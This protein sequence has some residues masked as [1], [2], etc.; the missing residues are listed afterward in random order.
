MKFLKNAAIIIMVAIMAL[1][2]TACHPK[3]EVAVTVGEYEFTSGYYLCAL[4]FADMEAR[5]KVDEKLAE[6]EDYDATKEVNYLKQKIDKKDFS[7]WVKDTAMDNIKLV[8]SY[9]TECKKAEL[10]LDDEKVANAEYMADYYWSSYGYASLFE[11]NGVSAA[12]FKEYMKDSYYS[13]LYFQHI[14]G[15]EGEKAISD[16]DVRNTISSKFALANILEVSFAEMEDA[17]K[18]AAKDKFAAY[19]TALKD[20]SRSFEEIYKEHNNVTDEEETTEETDT[21]ELKPLDEYASLVGNEDTNYAYDNFETI[22]AL[23]EGEIKLIT[24]EEDAG[25]V[26]VVKKNVIADPYYI[27]NLDS[28]ARYII[29]GEDYE[30]EMKDKADKLD[31]KVNDYAVDRLK[32]KNIKYPETQA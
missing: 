13:D 15:A 27:E 11:P 24:L 32:V 31:A 16:D 30:K 3:N 6:D 28:E 10:K 19:E 12:T 17:D 2:C 14:Y 25:L 22:A 29:A 5:G 4:V 7:K 20:G 9:K 21:E 26:L 1:G 18:T 23:K 8:A